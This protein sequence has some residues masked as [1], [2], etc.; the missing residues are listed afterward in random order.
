[1]FGRFHGPIIGK[2]SKMLTRRT[3]L[4]ELACLAA[5]NFMV[6]ESY[7]NIHRKDIQ[8]SIVHFYTAKTKILQQPRGVGV[9]NPP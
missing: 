4:V 2:G 7:S 1:M 9:E 5:C 3:I 8:R 6:K